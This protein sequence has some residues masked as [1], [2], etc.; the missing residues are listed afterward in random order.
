MIGGAIR[1]FGFGIIG[2][3]P[4]PA[5]AFLHC[6]ELPLSANLILGF[7]NDEPHTEQDVFLGD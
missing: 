2:S 4:F 1:R 6:F 5:L 7:N 3:L